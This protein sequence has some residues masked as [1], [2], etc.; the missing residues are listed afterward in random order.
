MVFRREQ[1][2]AVEQWHCMVF[3]SRGGQVVLP[4]LWAALGNKVPP[5][6]VING[7]AA[8]APSCVE[9]GTT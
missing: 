9:S 1:L 3:G 6:I 5:S 8:S 7:G 2:Q 4:E